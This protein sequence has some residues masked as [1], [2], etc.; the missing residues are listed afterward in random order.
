SQVIVDD[1]NAKGFPA[2]LNGFST[3]RATIFHSIYT[4]FVKSFLLDFAAIFLCFWIFF[5]SFGWAL[6]ALIPNLLPLVAVGGVMA[7]LN[8][9]VE[10]NLIVLIA[11]IL[12]I[13]VDDTTHFLYYLLKKYRKEGDMKAAVEYAMKESSVALI[14]TT[15]VF[16][17]TLPAFFLTNISMFS[18]MALVLMLALVLG[19]AGDMLVLPAL[20]LFRKKKSVQPEPAGLIPRMES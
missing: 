12:G 15:F 4:G 5:R 11:I 9:T 13:T 1:L 19:L 18:Q 10:Y 2:E 17:V 20:L 14:G 8:M 6:L 7:L 16:C 3:I